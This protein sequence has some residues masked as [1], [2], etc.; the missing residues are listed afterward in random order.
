MEKNVVSLTFWILMKKR[1]KKSHFR[2]FG[3]VFPLVVLDF[4]AIWT[5]LVAGGAAVASQVTRTK[6]AM[7]IYFSCFLRDWRDR[8]DFS[9][10]L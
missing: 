10:Q 1:G 9:Q 2:P 7:T 8:V 3:A 6:N 4:L 5:S